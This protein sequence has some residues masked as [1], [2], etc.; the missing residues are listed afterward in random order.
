MTTIIYA[1]KL[2]EVLRE[3]RWE[4][5]R[6]RDVEGYDRLAALPDLMV[7]THESLRILEAPH[8]GTDV[9]VIEGVGVSDV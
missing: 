9:V 4:S 6:A 7:L 5:L 8:S 3:V 2:S 1:Q